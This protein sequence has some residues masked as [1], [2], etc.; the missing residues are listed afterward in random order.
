MCRQACYLYT[1][2]H[3]HRGRLEQCREMAALARK[4]RDVCWSGFWA[5]CW[6]IKTEKCRFVVVDERRMRQRCGPCASGPD[7]ST[8]H[9]HPDR[10]RKQSI[11]HNHVVDPKKLPRTRR[12]SH[13]R[14]DARGG[15]D[16]T[17][18]TDG[19][20]VTWHPAPP[21]KA[22]HSS[23]HHRADR[24]DRN[25]RRDRPEQAAHSKLRVVNQDIGPPPDCPLP[26]LPAGANKK[27]K[28]SHEPTS[29]RAPPPPPL[30][31][32]SDKR[33]AR[34]K[35]HFASAAASSSDRS[36]AQA[37]QLRTATR[38][39]DS[40][41]GRDAAP[42]AMARAMAARSASVGGGQRSE[43]TAAH[44]PRRAASASS[45]KRGGEGGLPAYARPL[46]G[47]G[48]GVKDP[49][50]AAAPKAF[51]ERVRETVRN[52]VSPATPSEA[53]FAC[54]DARRVE[55]DGAN[56]DQEEN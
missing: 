28:K 10:P 55:E 3:T 6:D 26:P 8:L 18:D 9:P 4:R 50:R 19:F 29:Q 22:H 11:D 7:G 12:P 39:T 14:A 27:K 30:D 21:K 33:T 13:A 56:L 2:G 1:C 43:R 16:K 47:R 51:P 46:R 15:N 45:G 38:H 44:A 52:A 37:A 53:S 41:R 24:S 23:R 25:H 20:E 34:S 49:V 54:A 31:L 40:R 48:R 17:G 32:A 35:K 42:V 36:R 5:T